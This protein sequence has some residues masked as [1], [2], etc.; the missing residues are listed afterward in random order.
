MNSALPVLRSIR[1][2]S[3]VAIVSSAEL[4]MS[5]LFTA[6]K[7]ISSLKPDFNRRDM[8]DEVITESSAARE[9]VP[10]PS[11]RTQQKLPVPSRK[12]SQE[13]PQSVSPSHLR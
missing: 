2:M 9:P 3:R 13:S 7:A 1:R 6:S 4:T 10:M 5:A 12:V 11:L 8:R